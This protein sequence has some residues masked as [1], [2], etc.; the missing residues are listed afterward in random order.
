MRKKF[1]PMGDDLFGDSV[2]QNSSPLGKKF[3][4]PPFSTLNSREGLWQDRKHSWLSLG[5]ESEVGRGDNLLKMSD[6][7]RCPDPEKRKM[8]KAFGT[9]GTI[10]EGEETFL[11]TGTSIFDPVLCELAYEWFC[12]PRGTIIDPFAGGSVRGIVAG[13][14]GRKYF[15]IDLRK[16]QIEANEAQAQKICPENPPRYICGDSRDALIGAPFC[17]LV[18]SCP[19]YF[20]L[21]VYSDDPND[22][23][24]MSWEDFIETYRLI[25][26][27][28]CA[29]LKEDRFAVF[30]VG[31]VRDKEGIYR[32]FVGETISAF[33]DAGLKYYN[34]A[35]LI[36]SVGTLALRVTRQFDASRKLGKSHQNVLVFVKGDGKRATQ[37]INFQPPPRPQPKDAS[38][39]Q[40]QTSKSRSRSK[41]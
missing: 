18:F 25:I 29:R 15:G 35:I 21:E 41:S 32:N 6:T 8:A 27:E 37:A 12:P 24:T 20:D 31:D 30:V 11:T 4:F 16:E 10:K 5:I 28:A 39:Q 22:L 23:S 2:V 9:Q 19:P 34:E 38:C 1:S 33:I 14:L 40:T 13:K 3:I 36:N 17:D 26:S 7:I